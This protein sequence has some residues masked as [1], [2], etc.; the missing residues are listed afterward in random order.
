MR[1]PPWDELDID[2]TDDARAVKRAYSARLKVCRPED[3]HDGFIRLRAAYER[4]LAMVSRAASRPKPASDAPPA[5]PDTQDTTPND[6][7]S[8]AGAERSVPPTRAAH[9]S[10]HRSPAPEAPPAPRV[11]AVT[12]TRPG[13]EPSATPVSGRRQT[14]YALAVDILR[15]SRQQQP[16]PQS[17]RY[18]LQEHDGLLSIEAKIATSP[19]LLRLMQ[20]EGPPP[21]DALQT[22]AT[23]FDWNGV[24]GRRE[25]AAIGVDLAALEARLASH[26]LRQWLKDGKRVRNDQARI[27]NR[28]L[29]AGDGTAAWCMAAMFW[30]RNSVTRT[31]RLAMERFGLVATEEVMTP[32]VI[33]FWSKTTAQRPN[34]LQA[35]LLIPM[36]VAALASMVS[37][38]I[39]LRRDQGSLVLL[40][41]AAILMTLLFGTFSAVGLLDLARR[42]CCHIVLPA[43]RERMETWLGKPAS[44]HRL[45]I[46]T[47]FFSA[48]GLVAWYWPPGIEDWPFYVVLALIG[49]LVGPGSRAIYG[50]LGCALL[51][52]LA[53]T[54]LHLTGRL[55]MW[56]AVTGLWAGRIVHRWLQ[57]SGWWKKSL[58]SVVAVVNVV[59]VLLGILV[60][61]VIATVH[62]WQNTPIA[63][64]RPFQ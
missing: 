39:A 18:W 30:I 60:I 14:H 9:P 47:V 32:A 19:I 57:R 56:A 49:V 2:P 38:A 25:L 58:P 28:A 6:G 21:R 24:R 46:S 48:L 33:A 55:P 17:L 62:G 31:L 22:L 29:W 11:R 64:H 23:F 10:L 52:T 42:Y 43:N 37:V 4:A 13:V 50:F 51:V 15:Q 36:V 59:C 3:D 34:L 20:S 26:D 61:C 45:L 16:N 8:Q 7:E 1:V 54:A 63:T 40:A 12:R 35:S 27:L 5:S 53:T 41:P 44:G